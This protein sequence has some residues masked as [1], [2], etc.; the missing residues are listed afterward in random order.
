MYIIFVKENNHGII[1]YQFIDHID[2][3]KIDVQL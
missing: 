2:A 3:F 1:V